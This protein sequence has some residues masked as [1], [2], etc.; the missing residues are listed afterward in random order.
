MSVALGRWLALFVVCGLRWV[1]CSFSVDRWLWFAV[2]C[3][4]PV[5]VLLVACFAVSCY[6]FGLWF[7]D[8]MC[9]LFDICCGLPVS[10]GVVC[11]A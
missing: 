7:G 4:V 11:C 9:A 6:R 8:V 10:F 5:C 2:V 1:V 3:C